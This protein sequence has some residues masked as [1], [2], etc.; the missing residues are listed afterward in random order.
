LKCRKPWGQ[1]AG[2]E[3]GDLQSI[4]WHTVSG[5]EDRGD[6]KMDQIVAAVI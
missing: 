2:G 6:I 4:E 3:L 5:F 1:L